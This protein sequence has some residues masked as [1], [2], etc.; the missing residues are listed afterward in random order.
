MFA[1]CSFI[2]LSKYFQGKL[3]ADVVTSFYHWS[4][5]TQW[6]R[7]VHVVGGKQQGI[8]FVC[9]SGWIPRSQYHYDSLLHQSV[10]CYEEIYILKNYVSIQKLIHSEAYLL[11]AFIHTWNCLKCSQKYLLK[12][13]PSGLWANMF[14]VVHNIRSFRKYHKS[15][16]SDNFVQNWHRGVLKVSEKKSC[17]QWE[18]NSQ[19]TIT[20]LEVWCLSNCANLSRLARLR[21]PDPYK[22]VLY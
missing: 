21:L 19:L 6:E 2:P 12:S 15:D 8:R 7:K 20:A 14:Y 10:Y 22:V 18:F 11:T 13:K 17:L 16:I 3:V 1:K 5:K 9:C 4:C